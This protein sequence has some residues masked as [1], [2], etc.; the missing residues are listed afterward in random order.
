VKDFGYKHCNATTNS[1]SL[2]ACGRIMD[3][4]ASGDWEN[5]CVVGD[6]MHI[7][8]SFLNNFTKMINLLLNVLLIG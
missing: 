2:F 8:N 5:Y 1:T 7:A 4:A 3:N 6:H